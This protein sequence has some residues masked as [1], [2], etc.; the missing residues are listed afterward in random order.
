MA[1]YK[2]LTY[3]E[4]LETE[5]WKHKREAIISRDWGMCTQCM[6]SVKLNVHHTK[7]IND[8]RMAWE[9]PNSMLTTLCEKCHRG[10]HA[11]HGIITIDTVE[12]IPELSSAIYR[13]VASLRALDAIIER[14]RLQ[15]GK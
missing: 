4:Q 13:D 1:R 14:K 11:S 8:G 10:F 15:D 5:D 7:Y 2:Q 6:S 9:Y 12:C 3:Q